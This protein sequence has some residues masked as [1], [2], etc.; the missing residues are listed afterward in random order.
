M[1]I[2]FV[3]NEIPFPPDNG[4]RIVSYH[5]MR[6]MHEAG[7][8]LALTVLT[9]EA[10]NNEGRFRSVASFCGDGLSWWMQLPARG[11]MGVQLRALISRRM[12]FLE[13]YRCPAFRS[14]LLSLIEKFKPDVI[15][16]ALLSMTQYRDLAP[17]GV[18]T[19]ASINDSY[20]LHLENA[21][22]A[23]TYQG[24]ERLYRR[25][26]LGKSRRFEAAVYP[27]FDAVHIMASAD[28]AYLRALNPAICTAVVPNGVDSS[29]I[30]IGKQV[31]DTSDVIFVGQLGGENLERIEQFVEY[32][33]P[34][35]HRECPEVRLR[36]VGK[37][38]AQARDFCARVKR[39]EG[40]V[41]TDYVERLAD[42]YRE[43]GI[44]VV[45]VDKDCGIINKAI[46]A[47]AAG[48]VT[49]GFK[50]TFTGIVEA[51]DGEHFLS[52]AD[53]GDIGR[54]VADIIRNKPR[55]RAIQENGHRLAVEHYSWESRRSLYEEMY[56]LAADKAQRDRGPFR[57][58][59]DDRPPAIACGR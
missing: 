17:P 32:G 41:L 19:V 50:R 33:W 36:I 24:V 18:G 58:G 27:R 48:L 39:L 25:L 38:T 1:R 14:R 35:V 46:E 6:L 53:Y 55:R 13:R 4:R 16:F 54:V 5:A 11:R 40:I 52:G 7:H 42:A 57:Q 15:H 3:T 21:L 45:P 43:C 8:Q 31:R 10:D 22:R 47:M 20:S 23:G 2:L 28:G 56:K 37:I 9:A 51:K 29:L 59:R 34:A 49:V 26:Q 12:F 44:A 30:D